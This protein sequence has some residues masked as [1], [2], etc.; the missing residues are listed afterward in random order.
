M[1]LLS[2]IR[3]N[4]LIPE[5]NRVTGTG[6]HRL[7]INTKEVTPILEPGKLSHSH[8]HL[9]SSGNY[10]SAWVNQGL[11]SIVI[12]LNSSNIITRYGTPDTSGI[13]P[14][15]WLPDSDRMSFILKN[16]LFTAAPDGTKINSLG[17]DIIGIKP[18]PN[19]APQPL[20]PI[21]SPSGKLVAYHRLN[22]LYVFDTTNKQELPVQ[23]RAKAI[24]ISQLPW[25][26]SPLLIQIPIS[27][28]KITVMETI[29]SRLP[30]L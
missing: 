12:D 5:I 13:S 21:W 26:A 19:V 2:S 28:M 29:R 24:D 11:E 17:L 25:R 6:I 1:A 15:V 10:L 14:I 22:G 20:P 7:D 4:P 27:S 9:S 18:Q 30:I 23:T 3:Q 16:E 8:L